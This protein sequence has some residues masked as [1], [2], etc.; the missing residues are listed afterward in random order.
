M[1]AAGGK[2][3]IVVVLIE[4]VKEGIEYGVG[5]RKIQERVKCAMSS[6]TKVF[7]CSK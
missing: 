3:L 7:V 4:W 5:I 1:S 2:S 6:G